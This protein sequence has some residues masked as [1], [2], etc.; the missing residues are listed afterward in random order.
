MTPE[1][2]WHC[3]DFAAAHLKA[4]TGRD[5]VAELGGM[6][7][8]PREAAELYRR[9]GATDLRGVITALLGKP[10]AGSKAMR[11]DVVLVRSGSIAALGICRGELIECAD[12]ML[13]ASRAECC[14]KVSPF[15]GRP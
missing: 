11:G 7:R 8:G 4:L 1:W 2:G 9:F 13:P 6:P 10:D 14:W 12:N 15:R 3:A 5:I